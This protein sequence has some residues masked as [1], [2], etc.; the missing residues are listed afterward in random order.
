[1]DKKLHITKHKGKM[2]GIDSIST[3][4]LINP[5]CIARRE[6]KGTVCQKCYAKKYLLLRPSLRDK[7]AINSELLTFQVL[8]DSELPI[9]NN[10]VFR[11]E[12]FGD[13][14]NDIQLINYI[15]LCNKNP[16]TMFALWT[17]NIHICSQVFDDMKVEKPNN[18][19]I[20]YSSPLLNKKDMNF[21]YV[22]YV[23]H[24]F[25]VYQKKFAKDN[26]IQINCG[27]NKCI[28]CLKCYAKDTDFYINEILK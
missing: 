27:A 12:S 20:I 11:L 28:E 9:L 2:T 16:H 6:Q 14:Y 21:E 7:M 26:D 18:L 10:L 19:V 1:M 25:T 24:V 23:D 3:S 5:Y 4:C 22:T 8:K 17:K 13:L 15:N